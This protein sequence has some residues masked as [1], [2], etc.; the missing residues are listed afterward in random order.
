MEAQQDNRQH[1]GLAPEPDKNSAVARLTYALDTLFRKIIAILSS[2]K[3][4]P[5]GIY[6]SL[7]DSRSRFCLWSDGYG[8][9]NGS[10]DDKFQRSP[11]LRRVTMKTLCHLSSTVVDRKCRLCFS[12]YSLSLLLG[13]V[14]VANISSSETQALCDQV[15]NILE[16]ESC[17]DLSNDSSSD[18]SSECSTA[19]INEVAEDL[20]TDVDCLMELD[21]MLRD[22]ATDP[23]PES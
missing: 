12:P 3:E 17:S 15:S 7:D 23:E 14:P 6:K 10:M 13:L 2:K 16:E 11:R 1:D 8:I 9:A 20:E 22:P 4:F 5:S 21:Q 18:S 19:Q